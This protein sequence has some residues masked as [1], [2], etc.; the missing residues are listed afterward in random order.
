D[1]TKNNSS[2]VTEINKFDTEEECKTKTGKNCF[3]TSP[4]GKWNPE[5]DSTKNN[6]SEV[7]EINKFDTEEECKTKTGKNCFFTS[8]DGKWNPEF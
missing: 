6:S 5:M 2:E 4:D 7:T 8:P 3:F 1:S